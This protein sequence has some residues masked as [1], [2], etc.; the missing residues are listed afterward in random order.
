M[1][2]PAEIIYQLLLDLDLTEPGSSFIGFFPDDPDSAV[3]VYD[4]VSKPDGRLMRT[5]ERIEHPGVQ[6]Q[7]RGLAYEEVWAKANTI[8]LA[9]DALRKVSVVPSSEGSYIVDNVSRTGGVLSIGVDA[10]QGRRRH[11]FV[12]NANITVNESE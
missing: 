4:A 2:S 3:C 8:A 5:G 7:V 10:V 11:Y 9:L 12:I 6:I 1:N